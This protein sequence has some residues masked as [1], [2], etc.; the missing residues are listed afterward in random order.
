MA[1]VLHLFPRLIKLFRRGAI[2]RARNGASRSTAD[3]SSKVLRVATAERFDTGVI[4]HGG[5]EHTFKFYV[6]PMP[7]GCAPTG[8]VV[9]L[10]GCGQD[11]DDFAR[12]TMMNARAGAER[13]AV[14]YPAQSRE[15]NKHGCWN[16][17]LPAHQGKT[18]EPAWIAAVTRKMVRDLHIDHGSVFVA[19]LSA[20]G[21]MAA[22]VAKAYPDL[23]AACGVHSGLAADSAAGVI[24]ALGAMRTGAR[25]TAR[26]PGHHVPTIVFHGERD[27]TVHP[28][29]AQHVVDAA[30]FAQRPG[31]KTK[32][33]DPA[34]TSSPVVDAQDAMK[35]IG[36]RTVYSDASGRLLAE[37]WHLDQLQH[38]WSG[39]S[40]DGSHTDAEGPDASGV[41]LR[42]FREVA[43]LT[44][45][46]AKNIHTLVVDRA[47]TSRTQPVPV[48]NA[49]A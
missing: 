25:C 7:D 39:G 41:F 20:G 16:W 14:V 15:A 49:A 38:A 43:P 24:D 22:T 46:T 1:H 18:G 19:G 42:F 36:S 35:T 44:H 11:P 8:L 31:R 12:G 32:H 28:R 6:P 9:M 45:S 26:L 10:H 34:P 13:M 2:G 17:F 33:A 23:F 21:A 37:R 47:A 3:V 5:A 40:P 4:R 30:L 48:V 27:E 29:H